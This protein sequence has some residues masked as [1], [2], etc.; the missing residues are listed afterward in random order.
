MNQGFSMGGK[1]AAKRLKKRRE[2]EKRA[3]Q[4]AAAGCDRADLR[5]SGVGLRGDGAEGGLC[6]GC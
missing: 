4:E 2:Q 3:A 5:G 6:L 1:I